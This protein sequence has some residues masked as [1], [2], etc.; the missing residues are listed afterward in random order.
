MSRSH[1]FVSL[2]SAPSSELGTSQQNFKPLAQ[3]FFPNTVVQK[4]G[5]INLFEL[6]ANIYKLETLHKCNF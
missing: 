4:L 5:G 3:F 2:S 1:L 6:I